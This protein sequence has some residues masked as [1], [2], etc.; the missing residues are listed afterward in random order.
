[1]TQL[2]ND[3]NRNN[4]NIL[5]SVP[6]H[7]SW[8]FN[9]E[10]FGMITN[11]RGSL[12]Q[13]NYTLD[14]DTEITTD[15]PS[16][17]RNTLIDLYNKANMPLSI[18]ISGADGEIISR[19][20]K[21]LGIPFEF[22]ILDFWGVNNKSLQKAAELSKELC[23]PMNIIPLTKEEAYDS[24]LPNM[25][26]LVQAEKPSY[27]LLTY[28]LDHIPKNTYI[29]GGG[30]EPM[31]CGAE[32]EWMANPDGTYNG[33]PISIIELM[34]KQWA[35][36][37]DRACEMEFYSSNPVLLK[38]YFYHPLLIKQDRKIITRNLVDSIWPNLTFNCKTTNWEDNMSLNHDIR[39][40]LRSLNIDNRYKWRPNTCLAQ[41]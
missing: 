6:K 20:A 40:Y 28:L 25:F 8:A 24:V 3:T 26:K 17:V 10:P 34:F 33:I 23:I 9:N 14:K 31:K 30:G 35:I 19:A 27:L 32:Y 1:M 4:K 11:A 22:Y 15:L 36:M 7:I 29:I 39:M 38:S 2:I 16:A 5:L 37:N 13:F 21:E 12:F 18:C 41:I